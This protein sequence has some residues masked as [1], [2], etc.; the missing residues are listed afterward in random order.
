[1]DRLVKGLKPQEI[2]MNEVKKTTSTKYE[3]L[4]EMK[5]KKME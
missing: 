2:N 4:P 5:K 1:M 3:T